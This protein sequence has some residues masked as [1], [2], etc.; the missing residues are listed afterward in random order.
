M[1]GVRGNA[2]AGTGTPAGYH[3]PAPRIGEHTQEVLAEL[4]YTA[5]TISAWR[6]TGVVGSE[7]WVP[8]PLPTGTAGM[9]C[10]RLFL[11]NHWL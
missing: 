10:H 3:R 5:A 2:R 7:L 11:S 9:V 1:R 6:D 4:E 8:A